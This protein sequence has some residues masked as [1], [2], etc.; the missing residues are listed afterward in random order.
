MGDERGH[1]L[2]VALVDNPPHLAVDETWRTLVNEAALDTSGSASR[3]DAK[4]IQE[5][6]P[7]LG[8]RRPPNYGLTEIHE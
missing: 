1:G 4:E 5:D 7:T 2:L 8:K 3:A 6:G